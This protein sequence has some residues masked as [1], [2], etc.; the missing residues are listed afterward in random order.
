[1]SKLN[2]RISPVRVIKPAYFQDILPY[3]IGMLSCFR[4]QTHSH[5]WFLCY[6]FYFAFF[7]HRLH[8]CANKVPKDPNHSMLFLKTNRCYN[9]WAFPK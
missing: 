4:H 2:I 6:M 3:Y 1:M 9:K 7:C 8:N 5:W